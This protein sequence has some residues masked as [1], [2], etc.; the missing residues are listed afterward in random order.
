MARGAIGQVYLGAQQAPQFQEAVNKVPELVNA[1]QQAKQSGKSVKVSFQ[2][3]NYTVHPDGL[4]DESHGFWD[5]IK[6]GLL[7]AGVAAG[8]G[9]GLSALTGTGMFE[10]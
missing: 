6:H 5:N 4:F 1:R 3:H 10:P 9:I 2:G 7:A 8:A